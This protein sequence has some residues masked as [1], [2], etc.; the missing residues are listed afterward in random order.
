MSGIDMGAAFAAVTR[1][2]DGTATANF[3]MLW[4]CWAIII[5]IL[6]MFVVF[7]RA[8]KKAYAIA[9]LPL[10]VPSALYIPSGVLARYWS[11]FLPIGS[12]ELMILINLVA[13]VIACLLIALTARRIPVKANRRAFGI[14]CSLFIVILSLTLVIRTMVELG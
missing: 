7:M 5:V 12:I 2:S 6:A 14:G 13:G 4:A 11:R 3:G 1:S 9:I 10:A 8:N